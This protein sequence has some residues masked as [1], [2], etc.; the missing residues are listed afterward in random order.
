VFLEPDLAA[1][2]PDSA[3]VNQAPR[4]LVKLAQTKGLVGSRSNK[5]LQPAS[6]P[7][8]KAKSK[9]PIARGPRLTRAI[10]EGR[11]ELVDVQLE[12]LQKARARLRRADLRNTGY[13]QA[14]AVTLPLR[15]GAVSSRASDVRLK[16]RARQPPKDG[17]F[18]S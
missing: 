12:M 2:F 3:S 4:L 10:P 17:T 13:T 6:L 11:L 8:R 9:A 18:A 5:L 7:M 14:N 1:V 16:I 15:S